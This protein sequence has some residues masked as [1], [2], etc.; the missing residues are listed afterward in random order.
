MRAYF[1]FACLLISST[2]MCQESFKTSQRRYPRVRTAYAEK[3]EAIKKLFLDKGVDYQQFKMYLRIFKK[4]EEVQ[5]WVKDR[6]RSTYE[7]LKTYEICDNSGTIGPKREQGDLQVPEGFYRI[8]IFNPASN[9]FLSMG[10]NYPNRSDRILGTQGNL[11]GDI[12]IHGACVTIGCVPLTDEW[13]KE[14]YVICVEAKKGGQSI[15]PVTIFPT[16]LTDEHFNQLSEEYA[17]DEDK[18]GLWTDL[19]TGYELFNQNKQL[20][21]V[22]FLANGRHRVSK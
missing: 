9:F 19:K 10:I 2:A 18:I 8:N 21:N 7:L 14:L 17:D 5:L 16:K 11:G 20:P 12:Y 6:N 3:E 13:I 22:T 4:E 15:L 1:F